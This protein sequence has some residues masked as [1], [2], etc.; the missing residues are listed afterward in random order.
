MGYGKTISQIYYESDWKWVSR[1]SVNVDNTKANKVKF[2]G[3]LK[4]KKYEGIVVK[5][6]ENNIIGQSYINYYDAFSFFG[7]KEFDQGAKMV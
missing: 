5:D 4:D 6:R 2:A 7:H 1:G 3:Y